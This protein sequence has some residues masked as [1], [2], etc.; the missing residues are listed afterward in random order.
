[1]P[2]EVYLNVA[3]GGVLTA[4]VYDLMALGLL[5]IFGVVRI[6]NF[7]HGEMM[8]IAMY[9][10]VL[11]SSGFYLDPL[12]LLVPIAAVLFVFG[13]ALQTSLINPFTSRAGKVARS[14]LLQVSIQRKAPT[15]KAT[16]LRAYAALGWHGV[17][18]RHC[19]SVRPNPPVG[20][21]RR[22]QA[23]GDESGLRPIADVLLLCGKRRKG[24]ITDIP[25]DAFLLAQGL[26][27]E[28]RAGFSPS[29]SCFRRSSNRATPIENS[30]F[31]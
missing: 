14:W 4:L 11:L 24:P 2:R 30:E 23:V 7:A 6:V 8:T 12:I 21:Q 13:Y 17:F 18:R 27:R 31:D 29:Q 28:A 15:T 5:V 22:I 1:V 19:V 26:G 9:V 16:P 25:A 3:I 20:H 10:A